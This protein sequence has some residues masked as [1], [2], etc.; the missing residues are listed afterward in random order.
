VIAEFQGTCHGPADLGGVFDLT[1]RRGVVPALEPLVTVL[2][3]VDL[4]IYFAGVTEDGPSHRLPP[5]GV[6]GHKLRPP[7]RAN[8]GA[9]EGGTA[10]LPPVIHIVH[11][12]GMAN[13]RHARIYTSWDAGHV[14][15][16]VAEPRA[17]G[18]SVVAGGSGLSRRE[19]TLNRKRLLRGASS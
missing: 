10:M 18:L 4:A 16:D 1:R 15:E 19:A 17:Q 12:W 6:G 13:W 5:V 9:Q 14:V 7:T 8:R 11:R 2:E 3:P